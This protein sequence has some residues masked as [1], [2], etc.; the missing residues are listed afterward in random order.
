VI[1][2]GLAPDDRD[3]ECGEPVQVRVAWADIGGDVRAIRVSAQADV[4][5]DGEHHEIQGSRV[6]ER[7]P[8]SESSGE[9]LVLLVLPRDAPSSH[10]GHRFSVAWSLNAVVD[11]ARGRDQRHSGPTFKVDAAGTRDRAMLDAADPPPTS[12]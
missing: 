4:V 10:C 8:V 9:V 3:P 7:I 6:T 2:L 5:L 11:V 1:R 12:G